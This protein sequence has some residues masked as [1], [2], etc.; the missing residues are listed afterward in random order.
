MHLMLKTPDPAKR[1]KCRTAEKS[2]SVLR[3]SNLPPGSASVS[4][5]HSPASEG[6]KEQ[7]APPSAPSLHLALY[8]LNPCGQIQGNLMRTITN[9]PFLH[10]PPL[11]SK[12]CVARPKHRTPIQHTSRKQMGVTET[13]EPPSSAFC[14]CV[15]DTP[16]TAVAH[17]TQEGSTVFFLCVYG[18]WRN[19]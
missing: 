16:R 10:L 15:L 11:L 7:R 19:A 3:T 8:S 9:G 2:V 17:P 18:T 13:P 4:G 14:V 1:A 12:P 6:D 5:P